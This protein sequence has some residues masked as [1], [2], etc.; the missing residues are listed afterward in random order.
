[1]R[2]IEEER[3]RRKES[4]GDAPGSTTTS[5]PHPREK[6][7]AGT[8]IERGPHGN[9]TVTRAASAPSIPATT[10]GGGSGIQ[11]P[12]SAAPSPATAN[13]KITVRGDACAVCAKTVY[14]NEKLSADGKIFHK[15]CFRYPTVL[16][17]V[18]AVTRFVCTR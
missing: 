10:A 7:K 5:E 14:I 11:R 2:L 18:C 6:V 9:G 3:K 8:V 12:V 1:M 13:K 16:N 15:L 17:A 4:G